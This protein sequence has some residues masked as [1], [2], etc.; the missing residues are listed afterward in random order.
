MEAV[1]ILSVPR[2]MAGGMWLDGCKVWHDPMGE[3]GS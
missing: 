3:A 2:L 1:D